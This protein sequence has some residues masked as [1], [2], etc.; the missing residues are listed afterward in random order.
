[1]QSS[2]TDVAGQH[3]DSN[4]RLEMTTNLPVGWKREKPLC[5]EWGQCAIVFTKAVAWFEDMRVSGI[6]V[7]AILMLTVV[8]TMRCSVRAVMALREKKPLTSVMLNA[9]RN[10]CD[11]QRLPFVGKAQ[12]ACR[13]GELA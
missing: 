3:F 8:P 2:R 10:A 1:M 7:D 13:E 4:S 9:R 11:C 6:E 12:A 5:C